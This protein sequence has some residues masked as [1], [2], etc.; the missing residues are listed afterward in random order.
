MEKAKQ[1][2]TFEIVCFLSTRSV[3]YCCNIGQISFSCLLFSSL[4][5]WYDIMVLSV[6]Y[7]DIQWVKKC[8]KRVVAPIFAFPRK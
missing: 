1:A 4:L 5:C 6:L 3:S 7:M 8:L 2:V